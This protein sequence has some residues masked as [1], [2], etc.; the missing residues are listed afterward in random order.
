MADGLLLR[1]PLGEGVGEGDA[2]AA[3]L[4]AGGGQDVRQPHCE[5]PGK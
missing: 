4:Q 2:A 1:A 3:S 5:A